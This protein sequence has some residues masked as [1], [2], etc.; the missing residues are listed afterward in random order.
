MSITDYATLQTAIADTLNR[1]DLA[2]AI[3]TF[4]RLAEARI[5]RE[6]RHWRQETRATVTLDTQF[7]ALPADFLQPVRL[8]ITA[9]PTSEVAPA[10]TAQMLQRRT[11]RS[12]TPA[13][14][15]LYTLTGGQLELYPTPDTSYDAS[16]VYYA[17][18]P[19]LTSTNTTN[20]LLQEA[21]D[22]YLYGALVHT[23]PYLKDDARLPLWGD[24]LTQTMQGL[25][26]SSENAKYG[27]SGLV[28]R[29]R[30]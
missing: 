17:R 6:L 26:A 1:D 29:T 7:V 2:S 20:W 23:A 10:S 8:Q 15:E 27:G 19:A 16:L 18:I 13:R 12:D 24:L 3:P 21:P 5:D 30:R 11:D 22:A 25:T 4:V 28:M 14:P 9:A